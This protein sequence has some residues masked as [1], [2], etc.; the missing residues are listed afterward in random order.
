[1]PRKAERMAQGTEPIETLRN[2]SLRNEVKQ[3]LLLI[4]RDPGASA[5]AKASAGRTILEYYS[6]NESSESRRRGA[7]MTAAEI[8]AAIAEL[9]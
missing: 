7:E 4:L 9:D 3:A 2:T 5:A 1:M 8:D 6:D